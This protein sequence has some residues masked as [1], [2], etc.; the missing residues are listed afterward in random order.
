M[1]FPVEGKAI[2][3]GTMVA[4]SLADRLIAIQTA[5]GAT[6]GEGHLPL[7]TGDVYYVDAGQSDDS[8]DG[9]SPETA[10]KTIGAGIGLLSAGDALAIK[11]GTYTETGLDLNVAGCELWPEIGV[12]LDPASGTCLTI[13]ANYCKV[14][15][16]GGS[17]FV[18]PAAGETGVLVSGNNC[19]LADIRVNCA[20]T[21]DIGFD[22]TGNGAVLENCRCADPLEAA[23]KIQ[24]DKIKLKDCCTGGTPADTSIGYY[25]TNNADKFRLVSC[26]SQGHATSGFYIDAGCTNGCVR[27]CDSGVGDGRWYDPD[28]ATAFAGFEYDDEKN[29]VITFTSG[30]TY[31]LFQ[32]TGAV[33]VE[34]IYGVVRTQIENVAS[35]AYLQLYSTGGTADITDAPGVDI[36][37]AVAGSVI[38]RN[39]DSTNALNLA[40]AATPAKI[41]STSFNNPKVPID[42]IADADQTTYIRLVL[43]AELESG[44]MRWHCHFTP[45]SDNGWLEAVT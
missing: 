13:S 11:A 37:N 39:E 3:T 25:I 43:S 27:E 32:V 38:M 8:E 36:A 40:S 7:F 34:D 26:G 9:T 14:W 16:P 29:K 19:Y 20:S 23:F 33:R 18:T 42:L 4:G 5:L 6:E 1:G 2:N 17:M 22:L 15:C 31:N 41:E 10:K 12:I 35:T 28:H 44:V 24:G 45:L 21:A 30:T